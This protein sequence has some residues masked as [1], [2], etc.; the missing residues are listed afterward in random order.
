MT[1][2]SSRHWEVGDTSLSDTTIA[3]APLSTHALRTQGHGAE[4]TASDQKTMPAALVVLP[5]HIACAA[6]PSPPAASPAPHLG[7]EEAKWVPALDIVDMPVMT[8]VFYNCGPK[9]NPP[10]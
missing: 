3:E 8:T 2:L 5:V 9:P 7:A 10:R 4:K 6:S 1:V